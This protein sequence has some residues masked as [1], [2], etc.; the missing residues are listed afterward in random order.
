MA[1][2]YLAL[3]AIAAALFVANNRMLFG[4]STGPVPEDF[5]AFVTPKDEAL[6]YYLE[7][8]QKEIGK[9]YEA[10]RGHCLRV[11]SFTKYF[12][13]LEN[14]QLDP[15]I[16]NIIAMALAYHDIGL[17]TD[18]E[19]N[20]L[21]PSVV[22]MTKRVLEEM[23]LSKQNEGDEGGSIVYMPHRFHWSTFEEDSDIASTIIMEHHKFTS[24]DHYSNNNQNESEEGGNGGNQQPVSIRV[25]HMNEIVNAV[26]KADWADATMGV[27]RFGL[28]QSLLGAA[29]EAIPDAGFHNCL[30]NMGSRLSPDSIRGQMEVLKILKW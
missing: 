15:R 12:L 7:K 19:L 22:Q 21:E 18:K 10:Y 27:I 6:E 8:H 9:D 25:D 28:P 29:Y 24:Y 14:I 17:W 16:F 30:L 5:A 3:L 2:F 13:S 4:L 11:L 20:Y 1:S 26:R 23:K